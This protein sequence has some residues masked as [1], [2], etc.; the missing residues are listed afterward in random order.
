MPAWATVNTVLPAL[1]VM[2]GESSCSL[3]R[4]TG[5]PPSATRMLLPWVLA[6][7]AEVAV[8]LGPA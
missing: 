7:K 8:G 3:G 5:L 2:P 1:A 6:A 4:G